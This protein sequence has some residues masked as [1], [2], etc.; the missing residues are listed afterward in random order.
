MTVPDRRPATHS[1]G[2][3]T[4][5]PPGGPATNRTDADAP[6]ALDRWLEFAVA[7]SR[8]PSAGRNG[9]LNGH[10]SGDASGNDS[11]SAEALR[12]MSSQVVAAR[13][14]H[15]QIGDAERQHGP[16]VPETEIW[17]R[18]MND[19]LSLPRTSPALPIPGVPRRTHL[20]PAAPVLHADANSTPRKRSALMNVLTGSHP[21]V[22]LLLAAA[23]AIAILAVFRS[24]A[25]TGTAPVT[26]TAAAV[27]A[28][29]GGESGS[30]SGSTVRMPA[31]GSGSASSFLAATPASP[32]VRTPIAALPT[33]GT[34]LID[35]GPE[36]GIV[37]RPLDGSAGTTLEGPGQSGPP[38]YT[39]TDVPNV[40]LST[41]DKVARNVRTGEVLRTNPY[42][43][44]IVIGP[45]WV[46]YT[47]QNPAVPVDARIVDLRT[48]ETA[49]FFDLAGADPVGLG[50]A[51]L[52][53][54][55]ASGTLG[56]GV[57]DN[58]K[59]TGPAF[60]PTMLL[61]DGDLERTRAVP[62]WLPDDID[63]DGDVLAFSPDGSLVAYLT[64]TEGD[65]AIQVETI[66]GEFI[67][68]IPWPG[69][70]PIDR[71]I[72]TDAGTL[73]IM[74]EGGIST[75]DVRQGANLAPIAAHPDEIRY[76][77]LSPDG[78]H[79]LF[80][81]FDPLSDP[82]VAANTAWSVL[83]IGTGELTPI[84]GATGA[85]QVG[86]GQANEPR[87]V[88]LFLPIGPRMDGTYRVLF[89][90]V[91]TGAVTAGVP[92]GVTSGSEPGEPTSKDGTVFAAYGVDSPDAPRYRIEGGFNPL[93]LNGSISVFD[94][95][96]QSVVTI[97]M[98]EIPA[99]AIEPSLIVSPD[100]EYL[101]LSVRWTDAEGEHARSW[102]T[103]TDGASGWTPI[104]GGLVIQ[105][106]DD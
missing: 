33:D 100:G 80:A 20:A 22:S 3:A 101:V 17:E 68:R 66:S 38:M 56:V 103:T 29:D 53:E 72:L 59:A 97:P 95:G 31:S 70:Q 49:G 9:Y 37:T 39:R 43:N 96:S 15:A 10:A 67:Q 26:P 74:A 41:Y 11:Q 5:G 78:S 27:A 12:D 69:E 42:E 50:P 14:F 34:L 81:T 90:D 32:E 106:L 60:T 55:P 35:T 2:P 30:E 8:H 1:G 62:L 57:S 58:A 36:S 76:V 73:V 84:P 46:Q 82:N 23:V 45:F 77:V 18:I 86:I 4:G 102:L 7:G 40:A 92:T 83:D 25:E 19:R 24:F 65:V 28:I 54:G 88:M 61:I 93:E 75:V 91:T 99:T 6:D 94:A 85:T 47:S 89:V 63:F 21:A 98:P 104:D 71:L 52:F 79:L 48:M 64:G 51:W 87:I 13:E 105:W 16:A 44:S